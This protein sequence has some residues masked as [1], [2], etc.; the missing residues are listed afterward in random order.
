[1]SRRDLS[2]GRCEAGVSHKVRSIFTMSPAG[3]AGEP[4]SGTGDWREY[5][6]SPR[7]TAHAREENVLC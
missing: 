5:R 3:L 6:D 7:C 2:P 4:L 1:M